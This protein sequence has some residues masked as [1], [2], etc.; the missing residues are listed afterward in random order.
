MTERMQN[1]IVSLRVVLVMLGFNI[2]LVFTSLVF[3]HEVI[4]PLIGI[5][6]CLVS[7]LVVEYQIRK[8]QDE[9]L[10]MR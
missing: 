3:G 6:V 9:Y 1:L 4:S 5:F 2:G 10:R 7:W 8:E